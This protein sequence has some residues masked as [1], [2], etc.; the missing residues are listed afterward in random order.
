MKG[1]SFFIV[2]IMVG[3]IGKDSMTKYLLV[4]VDGPRGT[5][6][7]GTTYEFYYEPII[8]YNLKRYDSILHNSFD[9]ISWLRC[10]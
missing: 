9:L 1:H 6:A 3:L 2:T 7:P 8:F 5:N 10:S 4:E